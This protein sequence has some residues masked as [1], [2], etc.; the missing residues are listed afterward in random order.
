MAGVVAVF[1]LASLVADM[2]PGPRA[3]LAGLLHF[4]RG[5]EA[6][7]LPFRQAGV[8]AGLAGQEDDP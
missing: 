7:G 5:E 1:I 8:V 6:A 3:T 4:E 2:P